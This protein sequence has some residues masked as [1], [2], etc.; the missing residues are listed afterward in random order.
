VSY[1]IAALPSGG[2]LL[3][4]GYDHTK[5]EWPRRQR[6]GTYEG[7]PGISASMLSSAQRWDPVRGW[8]DAGAMADKRTSARA[9]ALPDGRALVTGGFQ[10]TYG[11]SYIDPSMLTNGNRHFLASAEVWSPA[12]GAWRPAAPM[13]Q[14]RWGHTATTL[15]DGRVLVVGG[16]PG[17]TVAGPTAAPAEIW[18]PATGGWTQIARPRHERAWHT[19]TR[20]ADGRVLITGGKSLQRAFGSTPKA[21]DSAE[22]WDPV[23]DRGADVSPMRFARF[24]HDAV[25][26]A[27]GR[28][29][30]AGDVMR[31]EIWDPG[32]DSWRRRHRS[33]RRCAVT[34]TSQRCGTGQYWR[35]A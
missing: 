4:G 7:P 1:A 22:V 2:A 5:L 27:D 9:A 29:L 3:A 20:L 19:A 13:S 18:T 6:G 15:A 21:L 24:D 32:T 17:E 14:P 12:T 16:T 28:V 30:V 10:T 23:T 11:R 8:R 34:S 25:L 35:C 26:L 33:R 31:S